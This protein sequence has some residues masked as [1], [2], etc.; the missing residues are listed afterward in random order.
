MFY[1][2]LFNYTTC[3]TSTA[4]GLSCYKCSW[5]DK[6]CTVTF[7]VANGKTESCG[8]AAGEAPGA[9][10]APSAPAAPDAPA[11]PAPPGEA[12]P[13]DAPP[14]EEAAPERLKVMR[15][16]QLHSQLSEDPKA[17]TFHCFAAVVTMSKFFFLY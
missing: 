13:A 16:K 7:D 9:P 17:D 1:L 2:Y 15:S 11:A 5:T 12:P 8:G 3:L 6:N 4:S 14:A 10:A